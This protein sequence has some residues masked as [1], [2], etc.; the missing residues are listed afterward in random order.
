MQEIAIIG[1]GQTPVAEQWDK[2]I[3]EIA[4]DAL[5]AALRDA[6]RETVDAIFVG[7]MLSGILANQENLGTLIADWTGLRGVEAIKGRGCLWLR[8]CGGAH[9]DAGSGFRSHAVCGS[10]GC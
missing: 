1:V 9:G 8:G 4:G 10:H 3:R 7:N 5:I 6:G 2:S